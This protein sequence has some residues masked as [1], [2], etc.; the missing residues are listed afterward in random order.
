[1]EAQF[2]NDLSGYGSGIGAVET[3]NGALLNFSGDAVSPID[4][5]TSVACPSSGV[6]VQMRKLDLSTGES[7]HGLLS[8]FGGTARVSLHVRASTT[9]HATA[10]DCSTTLDASPESRHSANVAD[11][12]VPI[13]FDAAF[14]ISPA[15][16]ADGK[17]RFGILSVADGSV[18]PTSFARITLCVEP[19][20]TLDTCRTEQFPARLSIKQLNA[21]ILLG[22]QMSS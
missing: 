11:P 19:A 9:T 10:P 18:Q 13:V 5:A 7:T 21:E 12:L 4:V 8:L 1:M 17:I 6:A 15:V 14:H 2:G 20:V 22:D 3:V 16:T